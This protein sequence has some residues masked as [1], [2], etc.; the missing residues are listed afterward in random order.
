[1][2]FIIGLETIPSIGKVPFNLIAGDYLIFTVS[3]TSIFYFYYFFISKKILEKKNK[4]LLIISGLL[5]LIIITIPV[6]L[7]YIYLLSA[8]IFD[9]SGNKF[10]VAFAKYY[11]I[12]LETNFLFAVSGSLLKIALLWYENIMRQKEIEKR[13]LAGELALLKS[14][15]NPHFLFNTLTGIK[16]L[17]EKQP[18]KAISSIENLS[19][20]MSYML[21]ET[22]ADKVPLNEE[23]N[24]MNNYLN[25]QKVKYGP[26]LVDFTV[27]GDTNGT[28]VPPLMFMPFMENAFKYGDC[29]SH[30]PGIIINLNVRD[31]NLLFTVMNYMKENVNQGISE[32]GFSI[33]SI[34]RHLDLQF[35]NNYSLEIKNED[36]KYIVAL[37]VKLS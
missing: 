34:K 30:I 7:I 26:E 20:I 37:N 8:E 35:E 5:F 28:F 27:K 21:Y 32:D 15:I 13:F 6:A 14:Q 16:S 12:F 9:L 3:F 11:F 29:I 33:N 31:N 36:N 1:M 10:L 2:L 22:T 25:L 19:E 4:A 18:G 17:I 23:I 24:N